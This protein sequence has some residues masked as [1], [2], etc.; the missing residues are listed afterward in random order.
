MNGLQRDDKNET[1]KDPVITVFLY[2]FQVICQKIYRNERFKARALIISLQLTH[3]IRTSSFFL[4]PTRIYIYLQIFLVGIHISTDFYWYQVFMTNG[5]KYSLWLQNKTEPLLVYHCYCTVRS[6]SQIFSVNA[7]D[8]I[9]M[10]PDK[11]T[12]LNAPTSMLGTCVFSL[13]WYSIF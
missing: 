5:C 7:F 6:I 3:G 10:H 12:E 9:S 11:Q 1:S 13:C 8:L 4:K 2:S